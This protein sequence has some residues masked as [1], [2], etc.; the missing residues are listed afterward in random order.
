MDDVLGVDTDLDGSGPHQ[1]LG[2]ELDGAGGELRGADRSDGSVTLA[3]DDDDGDGTGGSGLRALTHLGKRRKI[4]KTLQLI[5]L[6]KYVA[7]AK[8]L[9]QVPDRATTEQILD[10]GYDEFYYQGGNLH[11]PRLGYTAFLKLVRNRRG[12]A[13]RQM[14]DGAPMTRGRVNRKQTKEQQ[15]IRLLV[16]ELERIRQVHATTNAIDYDTLDPGDLRHDA[17]AVAA[18]TSLL[19]SNPAGSSASALPPPSAPPAASPPTVSPP[20]IAPSDDVVI[21]RDR[22]DMMLRLAQQ[23]LTQQKK[24]LEDVRAM[25]RRLEL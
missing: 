2:S 18:A 16:S 11:E 19:A 6:R 12:E 5:L 10:E 3:D 13:M 24:I 14:R 9:N 1:L 4:G 23:C 22:L 8:Q 20:G 21:S 17:S 25:E 7:C 15:E